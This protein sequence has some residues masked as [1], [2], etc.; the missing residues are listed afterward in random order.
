MSQ[1]GHGEY[2]FLLVLHCRAPGCHNTFLLCTHCY[3]GQAYCSPSCRQR[4]RILQLRAANARH[5]R[6]EPGRLDH[7]DRQRAY[8]RRLHARRTTPVTYPSSVPA[9]SEPSFLHDDSGTQAGSTG[10]PQTTLR[11]IGRPWPALR[12]RVCQR[13]GFT[14][15]FW[16]LCF[17]PLISH[18]SCSHHR[19]APRL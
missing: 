1:H 4:S 10:A 3:R 18:D 12:C 14:A 19:Y 7:N 9:P 15:A 11:S 13:P 17:F 2:V 16:L 8:R 6:T 5:Q